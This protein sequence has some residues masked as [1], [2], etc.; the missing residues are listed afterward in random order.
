MRQ[1]PCGR[2]RGERSHRAAWT[3]IQKPGPPATGEC[4]RP[5]DEAGIIAGNDHTARA[6]N[7]DRPR[8]THHTERR[9]HRDTSGDTRM[10]AVSFYEHPVGIVSPVPRSQPA[11]QRYRLILR[12]QPVPVS[13]SRRQRQAREKR[14]RGMGTGRG[15]RAEKMLDRCL[16]RNAQPRKPAPAWPPLSPPSIGSHTAF[17]CGTWRRR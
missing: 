12:P 3:E 6:A 1:R 5:T 17:P 15:V 8:L 16:N 4:W 10:A 11:G 14:E 2:H 7:S 9:W 13:S